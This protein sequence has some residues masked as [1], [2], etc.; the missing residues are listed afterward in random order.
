MIRV[1]ANAEIG[2][3]HLTRCLALAEMVMDEYETAIAIQNPSVDILKKCHEITND[4]ILMQKNDDYT[5][6]V[7]TLIGH[8]KKNDTIILDGYHFD[9]NYQTAIKEAGFKL[10]CIDDQPSFHFVADAIINHNP[11]I[12]QSD[13]STESYTKIYIGL[14]F[15]LLRKEFLAAATEKRE[16]NNVDTSFICF[17]GADQFNITHKALIACLDSKLFAKIN[18]VTGSAYKFWDQLVF[19]FSSKR[20]QVSLYNN[21]G[22][23]QMVSLLKESQIAIC[24]SSSVSL[25]VF[26]V[27]LN[28]V[29]GYYASNQKKISEFILTNGLGMMIGDLS[30]VSAE[31]IKNALLTEVKAQHFVRQKEYM[32]GVNASKIKGIFDSLEGNYRETYES[33]SH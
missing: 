4:I 22:P 23:A 13:Y 14:D 25:E 10:V 33:A 11:G 29:T 24:P 16:I 3:G 32:K 9:T 12:R 19:E 28:L 21:V 6:D 7:S 15:A 26:C 8:L 31:N 30:L 27:G 5:Q 20:P 2:L 17:G 1:D 18:V